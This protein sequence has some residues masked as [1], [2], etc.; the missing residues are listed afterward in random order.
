MTPISARGTPNRDLMTPRE[1]TRGRN[2]A[3]RTKLTSVH[4]SG[5]VAMSIIALIFAATALA[6]DNP[7]DRWAHAVGGKDKIAAV[8]AIY[9]E[10]TLEFGGMEGSIKVWHTADGR[11]RKE[12]QV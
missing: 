11:Y 6:A 8:K 1:S 2:L 12:E 9:R 7:V 10:G 4:T 3:W 5:G